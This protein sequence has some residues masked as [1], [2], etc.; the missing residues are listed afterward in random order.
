MSHTSKLLK[1]LRL[2]RV[3]RLVREVMS[4]TRILKTI[5]EIIKVLRAEDSQTFV[6]PGRYDGGTPE[7]E[8]RMMTHG[9]DILTYVMKVAQDYRLSRLLKVQVLGCS[10]VLGFE[11][12]PFLF[13]H[14][15]AE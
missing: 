2:V 6:L 15:F 11:N 8:L 14:E 13:F 10:S 4:L 7:P 5:G 12:G 9:V 3:V 1:L